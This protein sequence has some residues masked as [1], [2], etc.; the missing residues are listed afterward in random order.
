MAENK[1]KMGGPFP[2]HPTGQP[3]PC[4]DWQGELCVLDFGMMSEMPK[5][6]RLAATWQDGFSGQRGPV[7]FLPLLPGVLQTRLLV[8]RF[9]KNLAT[10]KL[11]PTMTGLDWT[12]FEV[13][14]LPL[15]VS[16]DESVPLFDE[17]NKSCCWRDGG[18]DTSLGFLQASARSFQPRSFNT[19]CMW[20]TESRCNRSDK[21]RVS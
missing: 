12:E 3:K 15:L 21:K 20:S 7:M 1:K 11:D 4:H 17:L 19:L 14:W 10:R 13:T 8:E 5:D 6:A 9:A 18:G 2:P 16:G